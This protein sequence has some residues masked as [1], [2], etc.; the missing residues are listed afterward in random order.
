M[1]AASAVRDL[2]LRVRRRAVA[3]A[4][5]RLPALTRL[6]AREPLPVILDRRRIY[7]LPSPPGL[8][9]GVLVGAM[10][11][12]GLNYNNN[13]ALMLCFFV[14]SALHTSL[15]KGYLNLRG[16]RL[17]QVQAT[18]VHAGQPV[19]LRFSFE[20][21]ERRSRTALCLSREGRTACFAAP[22]GQVAEVTLE[23]PT[24]RRG[25]MPIGRIQVFTRHP[26]GLFQVWSWIHPDRQALVYPAAETSAPPLPRGGELADGRVRRGAGEEPHSLRDYRVGDPLRLVAWKRSARTGHLMVREFETPRGGDVLLDWEQLGAVPYELRIRR[27]ARWVLDAEREGLRSLLRVPGTRL[28]PASGSDHVH[29]CLRVLALLPGERG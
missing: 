1:A 22:V 21:G 25:W 28:G 18:P 4:E 24:E 13:P 27:L 8:F 6:R 15:L 17:A 19:L 29:A 7:V 10:L 11:V 2:A 26:L 14:A 5:R 9:F 3:E 12:G 20:A 23:V 16:L